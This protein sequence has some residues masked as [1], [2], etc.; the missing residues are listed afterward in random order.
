[1]IAFAT[2]DM[3]LFKKIRL[4]FENES[5]TNYF[6]TPFYIFFYWG[7]VGYPKPIGH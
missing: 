4:F 1:M 6:S 3:T 2:V 7:V 5:T